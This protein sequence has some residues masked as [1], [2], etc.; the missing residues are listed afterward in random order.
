M[1][2]PFQRYLGRSLSLRDM[3]LDFKRTFHYRVP[4]GTWDD[5]CRQTQVLYNRS[6]SI[7]QTNYVISS[8]SGADLAVSVPF[9][10][11]STLIYASGTSAKQYIK[12]SLGARA[13]RIIINNVE[14][15]G[16]A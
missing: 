13:Q 15:A 11:R 16:P 9:S 1:F 12:M 8:I 6:L 4:Q 7:D 5:Y 3:T 14:Y 10:T 2:P